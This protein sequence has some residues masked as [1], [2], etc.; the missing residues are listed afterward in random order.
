MEL[1]YLYIILGVIFLFT[2]I[3]TI[4]IG[5]ILR[6]IEE[7]HTATTNQLNL[8][9]NNQVMLNKGQINIYNEL[10]KAKKDVSG[11]KSNLKNLRR[12]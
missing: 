10:N 7:N 1:V 8:L 6:Y 5:R 2:F 9:S 3:S 11:I 12:K 4:W